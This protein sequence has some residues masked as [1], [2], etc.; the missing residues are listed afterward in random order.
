MF[1]NIISLVIVRKARLTALSFSLIASLALSSAALA[2][3][4][5]DRVVAVVN[6][7]IITFSELEEEAAPTFDK[8]RAEAPPA[9]VDDAIQ[10][11]RKE[12]L[13][14]MIDHKLLLQR[15]A[16]RKIE[17]SDADIDSAMQRIMEQNS[18]TEEQFRDQLATM[19]VSEEKYRASLRDQILRSRL[20][21]YEIRSK[22]VITNEQVEAYY[23]DKYMQNNS[24]EGY[25]IL[26]FGSGWED[27][28]RSASKEEAQKRA[29][30]LREMVLA[31]E[32]FNEIAKN[33][34]DLPSGVDGG[35]IGTFKK[36]ELADYMW[37]SIKDLHPGEVSPVVETPSGFQFF[38]LLSRSSD[39]V[40]AQ[41][42][43]ENVKDEIRATL[44]D[45]ELK[46]KF[47]YWVK[48]LRENSYVK[49]LL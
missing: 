40:I 17:V 33:Y 14:N 21:S 36:N 27:T 23:R 20:L 35:D 16:K 44:Y 2:A 39:G 42:P 43:L 38:K 45:Q 8:I 25:H 11:A 28:G 19:G 9:Q 30:Q 41:A 46:K 34:S 32:N 1:K 15:A 37:Q 6:D 3:E 10:K 47:E 26:Q 13:R 7:D 4:L 31:G 5:V 48:E 29:E 18:L 12:I 22:V 49:E 24:P